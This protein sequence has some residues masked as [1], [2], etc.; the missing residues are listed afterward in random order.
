MSVN[1][2]DG[3]RTLIAPIEWFPRPDGLERAVVFQPGYNSGS[4]EY[5]VHGMEIRWLLRGPNGAA[6]CV[7]F[8]DWTPGELKPGHGLPP[9][10]YPPL[11]RRQ[12]PMGADLGYHALVPQYEGQENYARAD[13]DVIPGGICY[14]DGSGMASEL[15][16]KEFTEHGEPVIWAALEAQYADLKVSTP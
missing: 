13:C 3:C 1:I 10:G 12:Y 11:P 6:Q 15:L 16:A 2:E 7:F 5:G 4:R 9:R 8:T 14:Y